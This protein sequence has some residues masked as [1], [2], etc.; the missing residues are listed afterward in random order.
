MEKDEDAN[1]STDD[2]E[3]A[4]DTKFNPDAPS[5]KTWYRLV[6]S[7]ICYLVLMGFLRLAKYFLYGY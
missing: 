1:S 6:F 2:G 5:A 3:N 4:D 7:L